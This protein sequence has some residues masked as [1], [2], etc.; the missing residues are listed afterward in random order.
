M[1]SGRRNWPCHAARMKA[2][3]EQDGQNRL[4]VAGS[5]WIGVSWIGQAAFVNGNGFAAGGRTPGR[6]VTVAGFG[7]NP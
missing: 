4:R 2:A 3:A 6:R 1:Q 7:V 5:K